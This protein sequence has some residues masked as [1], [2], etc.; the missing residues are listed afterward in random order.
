[1]KTCS[2]GR[3]FDRSVTD[4]V[5]DLLTTLV[6]KSTDSA[7]YKETMF[8]IGHFMGKEL[9][10]TLDS[11]KSYCVAS[12][13]EDA[14]FLSKGIIEG[15]KG[16]VKS[17]YLVCFWNDRMSVNGQSVAPIY[18]RYLDEGFENSESLI[19]VKS[20]ISGSCVVKTNITAIIDSMKLSNIFVLAPVM[21][22]DS[23]IKLEMEFPLQVSAL[24]NYFSLAIDDYKDDS[25]EVLPGIGGSVY[26]RLG[27]SGQAEKNTYMPQIIQER[28]FAVC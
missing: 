26:E 5:K 19:V 2:N 17:V 28:M 7:L 23:Q 16:V 4:D 20:I 11:S 15:L 6:D 14:D 9:S 12:T 1:M 10:K 21:H 25:G 18:N 13:V 8:K 27:F 24:F 3:K 22:K